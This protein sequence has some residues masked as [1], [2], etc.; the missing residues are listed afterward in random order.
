MP[1]AALISP[2]QNPSPFIEKV[3][4]AGVYSF[5]SAEFAAYYGGQLPANA[6][7]ALEWLSDQKAQDGVLGIYKKVLD[8]FGTEADDMAFQRYLFAL[9]LGT[10]YVAYKFGAKYSETPAIVPSIEEAG[11]FELNAPIM[12]YST[13]PP[14]ILVN[15]LEVKG[16]LAR[17]PSS[18]AQ[19]CAGWNMSVHETTHGLK[20]MVDGGADVLGELATAINAIRFGLPMKRNDSN[21]A[22]TAANMRNFPHNLEDFASGIWGLDV[23]IFS[24]EYMSYFIAPW[25]AKYYTKNEDLTGLITVQK[26]RPLFDFLYLPKKARVFKP[27]AATPPAEYAQYV[28][29]IDMQELCKGDGIADEK[30]ISLLGQVFEELSKRK[31]GNIS[32]FLN[33]FRDEMNKVFGEPEK[34]DIPP[35]YGAINRGKSE[36][37]G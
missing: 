37:L 22:G 24:Y 33:S 30:L 19:I 14:S 31:Y 34:A 20:I 8:K 28:F 3:K 35:N 10:C 13:R 11:T 6:S 2:A 18:C 17:H 16:F 25:V 15:T 32:E 23:R 4:K 21:V 5:L 9:V 29:K 1:R 12:R 27:N 7:K 26:N 36:F